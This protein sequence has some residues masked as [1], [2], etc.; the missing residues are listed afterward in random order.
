MGYGMGGANWLQ[1]GATQ[2]VTV[3]VDYS[4]NIDLSEA[5]PGTPY[6]WVK[7]Y[8]AFW[9]GGSNLMLASDEEWVSGG[10]HPTEYLVKTVWVWIPGQATGT[11]TGSMEWE[12]E[13][14]S[15]NWYSFWGQADAMMETLMGPVPAEQ[16]TW[17]KVRSLYR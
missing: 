4:Y 9:D 6:A 13:V 11:V 14:V 17:G 15:G 1:S 12:V 10:A 3:R 7:I 16:S 2:S 8:V 5:H